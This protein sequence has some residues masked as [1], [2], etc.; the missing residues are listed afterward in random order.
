MQIVNVD[1]VT[2]FVNPMSRWVVLEAEHPVVVGTIYPVKQ[3]NIPEDL[4]NL[5]LF[6]FVRCESFK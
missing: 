1:Y 4:N 3:H 5:F 2:G 6:R